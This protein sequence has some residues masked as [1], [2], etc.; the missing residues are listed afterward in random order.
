MEY[1]KRFPVLSTIAMIIWIIGLL[2]AVVGAFKF[3]ANVIETMES[4]SEQQREWASNDTLE[5]I[6]GLGTLLYGLATMAGAEIIGVL[7]AIEKNTR[8]PS[9]WKD[10]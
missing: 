10:V 2:I 8:Q 6:L 3:G 7:F 4:R 5:L 9:N 1:N